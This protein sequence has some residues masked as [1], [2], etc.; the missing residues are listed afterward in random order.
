MIVTKVLQKAMMAAVVLLLTAFTAPATEARA[1]F[2][3]AAVSP[4]LVCVSCGNFG[5]GGSQEH[6]IFA[7]SDIYSCSG[8]S[9]HYTE[10]ELGSCQEWHCSGCGCIQG[11][12][13]EVVESARTRD[14]VTRAAADAARTG[15]ADEVVALLHAYGD[16]VRY[17]A[18]R[19]VLQVHGCGGN[20]LA[21]FG[22][23]AH[24]VADLD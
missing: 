1:E 6:K 24:V 8:S 23:P 5:G 2:S 11:G 17:N 15:N 16:R 7:G 21:Q 14:V 10:W 4:P 9:C 13:L 18:S 12:D 20:V 19:A 3:A 22:L